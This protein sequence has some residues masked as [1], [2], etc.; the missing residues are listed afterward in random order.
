MFTGSLT[1]LV[2]GQS[3]KETKAYWHLLELQ[4]DAFI[5]RPYIWEQIFAQPVPAIYLKNKFRD[6]LTY[7][8][9]RLIRP[10]QVSEA[11]VVAERVEFGPDIRPLRT[12]CARRRPPS[13][14]T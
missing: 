10:Q 3:D 6:A 1:E 8:G 11:R 2:R 12:R 5:R 9:L 7:Y 13:S 4:A 14:L